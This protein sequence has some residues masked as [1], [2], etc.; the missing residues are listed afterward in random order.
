LDIESPV[1]FTKAVE[2]EADV[3]ILFWEKSSLSLKSIVK[4]LQKLKKEAIISIFIGPEGGYTEEE[5]ALAEKYGVTTAS[6]GKR[7][8]KV[9]TASVIAVALIIYEIDNI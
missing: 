8:F 2:L 6:M 5:T 9:E 7:I 1:E 3:K 4:N